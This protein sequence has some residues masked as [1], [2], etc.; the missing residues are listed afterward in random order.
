MT[1]NP[2]TLRDLADR[3]GVACEGLP[4]LAIAGVTEDSRR[5]AP[6]YAFVAAAGEHVDGHAFAEQAVASGA[7][8]ILG[9]REGFTEL[10]GV[11]YV[12]VR[13]ARRALGQLA[14]ALAGDPT[15]AMKVFG[16]TGTNGKTSVALIARRILE[17]AGTPAALFG[18]LTYAWP[19]HEQ[20]APL[21]TPFGEHLAAMFAEA[22]AAGA[23]AAV[24]EVSSHAL[25][26]ERVAGIHYHSA[27][28]TN[29]TQDHLDYH[30][31]MEAYCRAKAKLFERLDA[32]EGFA[33]LNAADPWSEKIAPYCRAPVTWYGAEAEVRAEDVQT[34][35]HETRFRFVSPWGSAQVRSKLL[36]HYNVHNLVCAAA[37]CARYGISAE[38][39]AA[40]LAETPPVP[41]RFEH[42]DEGQAFLV[43][44][45]YAHTE[46]GLVN[47]L[48]A[49]RA[50]CPGRLLC[51]FGCG[52][53]R[54]RTK[55]PKMGHAAASLSDVAIVTS[56]NPRTEDP[57]AIL[58]DILP[59]VR[60]GGKHIGGGAHVLPDRREAI[61]FAINEAQA[62]DCVVI[63]GKGHEDY[64]IIGTEK[65][66]FDDREEARAALK[67]RGR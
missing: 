66:H 56:D 39:I 16:V 53:D 30:G 23:Q 12:R 45:D 13:H 35:L 43:I 59:G 32:A 24:M 27:A 42:V 54:D 25:E 18:T 17:H 26:Q 60:D 6:G 11:P 15:A 47:V 38:S 10:A 2:Q 48:R 37:L 5:A 62:D 33:V 65:H 55:R 14:H 9:E 19:G 36:G 7:H 57:L 20:T 46:D 22:R 8:V 44:V 61:A 28:F 31:T 52:G 63:A 41:G 34:S 4:A 21:T 1:Q 40:A 64:Q 58:E 51:V 49:A 29:L 3:L 67:A 50:I